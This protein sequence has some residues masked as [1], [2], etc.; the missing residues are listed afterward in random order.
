MGA[1]VDSYHGRRKSAHCGPTLTGV[2][3]RTLGEVA[4]LLHRLHD[5][6]LYLPN[7]SFGNPAWSEAAHHILILRLSPFADVQRSTPHLFL[8]QESRTALPDSFI[9]IGFLPRASD[10]ARFAK[11]GLPLIMGTQS[12]RPLGDFDIVLVS[13][14]W[15]LEQVNLP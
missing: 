8:F 3:R 4:L 11:A 10:A 13:N 14:S 7:P 6:Q 2:I 12:H 15:L 9:D 5:Y 1:M